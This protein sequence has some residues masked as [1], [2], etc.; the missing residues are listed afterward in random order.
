MSTSFAP[1]SC[2]PVVCSFHTVILVGRSDC[3]F[4]CVTQVQGDWGVYSN[5]QHLLKLHSAPRRPPWKQHDPAPCLQGWDWK[6]LFIWHQW[7]LCSKFGGGVGRKVCR[8]L[9]SCCRQLG[10]YPGRTQR[11]RGETAWKTNQISGTFTP[12]PKAEWKGKFI[13][14]SQQWNGTKIQKF[15]EYWT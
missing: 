3:R 2:W 12:R 4:L 11:L 9:V 6:D 13:M 5:T 7:C 8:R 1:P 15:P 10:Q 14:V